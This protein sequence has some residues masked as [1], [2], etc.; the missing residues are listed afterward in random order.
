M[1]S[2]QRRSQE[3]TSIAK[4]IE[5]SSN[6]SSTSQIRLTIEQQHAIATEVVTILRHLCFDYCK[7]DKIAN[8]NGTAIT[9]PSSLSV[10]KWLDLI[11]Y[12]YGPLDQELDDSWSDCL[13]LFDGVIYDN[14]I[15]DETRFVNAVT[16]FRKLVLCLEPNDILLYAFSNVLK[17]MEHFQKTGQEVLEEFQQGY[18][19]LND[20]YDIQV[21]RLKEKR[22]REYAKLLTIKKE[23]DKLIAQRIEDDCTNLGR[24]I[25]SEDDDLDLIEV[26]KD[27]EDAGYKVSQANFQQEADLDV[28]QIQSIARQIPKII[29]HGVDDIEDHTDNKESNTFD[30]LG[31]SNLGTYPFITPSN[32]VM[33][34][35]PT[36]PT[37]TTP[38]HV[39]PAHSTQAGFEEVEL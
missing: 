24:R 35:H 25:I 11:T 32:E 17:I 27:E 30:S 38:K 1:T 28:E 4:P 2:R 22:H 15:Q 39:E 12:K 5:G 10:F 36:T 18:Y 7:V 26:S 9:S 13:D 8:W 16:K 3:G 37:S 34:V 23:K 19:K 20:E 33:I 21:A 29:I 31:E 14:V 6:S